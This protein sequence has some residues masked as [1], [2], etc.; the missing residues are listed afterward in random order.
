VKRP[1]RRRQSTSSRASPSRCASPWTRRASPRPGSASSRNGGGET[2]PRRGHTPRSRRPSR[3]RPPRSTATPPSQS[4]E[5]LGDMSGHPRRRGRPLH[6]RLLHRARRPRRRRRAARPVPVRLHRAAHE[7]PRAAP[8]AAR[9]REGLR[10]RAPEEHW[11]RRSTTPSNEDPHA[12]ARRRRLRLVEPS[13]SE[14]SPWLTAYALWG[15]GHAAERGVAVPKP[16]ILD[17]AAEYLHGQPWRSIARDPW[18]RAARSP[19]SSTCSR[20]AAQPDTGRMTHLVRGPQAPSPLFAQA[21]LLH[22]LAISQIR[23]ARTIDALATE[24]ET[25][26]PPRRPRREASSPATAI[27]YAFM[28]RLRH[29]LVRPRAARARR[30]EAPSTRSR[31]K[32][33]GGPARRI[34]GDGTWRT[35]QETAWVA[36]RARQVPPRAGEGSV[37]HFAARL[38]L[39]QA[40]IARAPLRRPLASRRPPRPSPRRRSPPRAR[41]LL[42]FSVSR[43]SGKPLLRGAPPL[44]PQGDAEDRP[45]IA[46]SSSRRRYRPVKPEELSEVLGKA[47]KATVTS[48]GRDLARRDH[49]RHASQFRRRTIRSSA[50]FEAIDARLATSLSTLGTTTAKATRKK[51]RRL[52]RRRRRW[53]ALISRALTSAARRSRPLLRRSHVAWLP[54]DAPRPSALRPPA[55]ARRG[56]VR[57]GGRVDHH[58]EMSLTREDAS[59]SGEGAPSSYGAPRAFFGPPL[60]GRSPFRG[61]GAP[62]GG[63]ESAAERTQSSTLLVRRARRRS[64]SSSPARWWRTLAPLRGKLGEMVL[65][66]PHRGLAL[67]GRDPRAVR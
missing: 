3:S 34:A 45:S 19:S 15:L 38:F 13:R 29:A 64:P 62:P 10:L 55:D 4:V 51:A 66:A 6:R 17:S 8:P 48:F 46:A 28:H 61:G 35:T 53:A 32:L 47:A 20:S 16:R 9:S 36:A 7:P 26:P 33:V 22:A 5:A 23:L 63:A 27:D 11:T 56:D 44:R 12:P 57:A 24:L 31:S 54:I 67:Q 2:G 49:R 58:L 42:G 41:S 60:G 25:E 65:A 18:E 21:H 30:G 59:S 50:G 43:A 52:E 1:R 39:G 40:E 14:S 37:P